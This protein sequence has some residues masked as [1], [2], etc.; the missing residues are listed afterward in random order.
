MV[1]DPAMLV[2]AHSIG[3]QDMFPSA[4]RVSDIDMTRVSVSFDSL[5]VQGLREAA[6]EHERIDILTLAQTLLTKDR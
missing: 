1:D 5:D 6:A 2:V 3:T 4:S